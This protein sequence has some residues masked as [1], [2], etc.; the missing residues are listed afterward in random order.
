MNRLL[1]AIVC[2]IIFSSCHQI[3]GS[4]NII[5]RTRDVDHFD[6]VKASGSINIEVTNA[7]TQSVRI[8]AD[9]NIL[10][11]VITESRD[12][13]LDVH[14][15]SN[16][17]YRNISVTVFVTAPE[18]RR[19]YVSGSGG[20]TST[21]TLKDPEQI[22]LHV[23]GSGDLK[24]TV[25]AP[26]ITARVSGSGI[27]T[28]QGRTRDL[29]STVSGSGDLNCHDL[30]SEKANITVSG[31]G[32]AHVYSSV[33]LVAKVSGSGDIIYSGNPASPIIHKSGSGSVRPEK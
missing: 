29:N 19:L 5:T 9:D 11:Y 23:S 25:D 17:S 16:T 28:L 22:E 14:L 2:S 8:E 21:G 20:I 30:L 24:A 26:V 15:K 12:G 6:G 18:L 1:T 7:A 3:T 4:G 13:M 10:P 27:I 33:S 31:S 32:T